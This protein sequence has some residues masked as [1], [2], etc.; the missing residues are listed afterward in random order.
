M[1]QFHAA[2]LLFEVG[3]LYDLF[4]PNPLI[5]LMFS[6]SARVVYLFCHSARNLGVMFDCGLI[7]KQQV[8]R[9]CQTAYFELR[10]IGSIVS[11][12]LLRPQKFFTSL[13]L[14]R[15]DYC[16]S[17]MAGIPQKLANKVR[18]VMNC[19]ALLVCKAPKREHVT[20]LLVDLHW[21]PVERRTEY[22]IAT[23]RSNLITGT[24]PPYL[25]DL[26]ELYTPSRTLRSSADTR[27]FRSPNR[28]KRFQGQR[29]FFCLFLIGPSI[30]NNLPFSRRH[31]QTLSA[32]KSQLK[33]HL[34]S[35]SYSY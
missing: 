5:F 34:F 6:E 13:V 10:R 19:A 8:D 2:G 22:K 16:N 9:I 15:L 28:R 24:G 11:F 20:S 32:F 1:F 25:S 26:L 27:I 35:I 7:M 30:W 23:I 29:A 14:S 18:R 17:L 21:L 4:L 3:F 33:T 31:A 12:L